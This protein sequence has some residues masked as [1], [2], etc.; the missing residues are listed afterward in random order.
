MNPN[1]ITYPSHPQTEETKQKISEKRSKFLKENPDKH[2][3]K[4]NDK[5]ISQ[6]C[7]KLKSFLKEQG[8]DFE[9]EYT[10]NTWNHQYSIDI[11]FVN[12]KIA[13]EVN[14]NQHYQKDGRLASYYQSRHEF[15]ESQGW[16]VI[17]LHYNEAYHFDDIINMISLLFKEK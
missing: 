3:W 9:E 4:R 10:D 1:R 8:F 5:F 6:P 15:L 7:E 11:A 17:E 12:K 14:G 16:K 13:I 2:P